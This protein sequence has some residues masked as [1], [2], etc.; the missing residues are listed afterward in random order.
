M[1]E[2][3]DVYSWRVASE[4]KS[5]LRESALREGETLASLLDRLAREY[6]EARRRD[7]AGEEEGQ[8][9]LRAQARKAFGTIAG[10]NARRAERARAAIRKRL[11]AQRAR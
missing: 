2:K 4:L 7:A 10:G 8:A 3:S 1:E 5:E 9:R 11:K 6:L